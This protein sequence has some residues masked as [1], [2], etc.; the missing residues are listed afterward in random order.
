[1][2]GAIRDIGGL[3]DV[4]RLDHLFFRAISDEQKLV[5]FDGGFV[6]AHAFSWDPQTVQAYTQNTEPA[7]HRRLFDGTADRVDQRTQ[8]YEVL[9]ARYD[10]QGGPEQTTA[11]NAPKRTVLPQNLMQSPLLE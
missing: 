10:E 9:D 5:G 4:M 7:N 2:Q 1:M 11:E 3:D 6:L 8:D